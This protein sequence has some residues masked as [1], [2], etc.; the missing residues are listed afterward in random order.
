[1]HPHPTKK[2]L[3]I[4]LTEEE[5]DVSVE[6]DKTLIKKIK[7]ASKEWKDIPQ[8]WIGRSDI[9]KMT[10]LSKAIYRFNVIPIKLS[11]TLFT[12][13]EQIILKCIWNHKRPRIDKANL[14]GWGW[15]GRRQNSPRLQ[16]IPQSYSNQNSVVLV[17]K[18]T[19]HQRN[20]KESAEI[21]PQT[22]S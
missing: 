11:M 9:V 13:L 8:Y 2:Y 1:M 14:R 18:Q 12:E 19:Y 3:G 16:A 7:K 21:N 17:Q 15:E 22:Y 5:K 10:I 6:N 4:N 20:R